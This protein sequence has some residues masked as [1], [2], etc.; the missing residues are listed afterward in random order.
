MPPIRFGIK[1]T[2]LKTFVPL[3]PL[4][5]RLAKANEITFTLITDTT[6]NLTVNHKAFLKSS[7]ENAFI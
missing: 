1:N 2:V 7:F 4:V 3:S 6:A 5:K